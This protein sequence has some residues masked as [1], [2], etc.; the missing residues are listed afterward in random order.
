MKV[1][2]DDQLRRGII[3]TDYRRDVQQ[4]DVLAEHGEVLGVWHMEPDEWC[5]FIPAG[6]QESELEAPSLWILHDRIADWYET[7]NKGGLQ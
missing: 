6:Q 1:E 4:G 3:M 5:F 7:S 2:N